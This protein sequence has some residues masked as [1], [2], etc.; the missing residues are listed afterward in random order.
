M[1]R[2]SRRKVGNFCS[3]S[4]SSVRR[5]G[6]AWAA[7][8]EL[9]KKP[10]TWARSRESGPRICSESPASWVS[11]SRWSLRMPN[12]AVDVAQDRVGALDR[13]FD[14]V[15]AAGEAGA[16]FV[17]DQTEALRVGQRVGCR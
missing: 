10:A 16:E 1:V 13:G 3:D 11:W 15:A 17:E 8:P 6:V 9:V 5:F 7:A 14:V 2:N 12:Q 4:S